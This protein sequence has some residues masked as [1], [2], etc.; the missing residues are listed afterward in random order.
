MNTQLSAICI[1]NTQIREINGLY[2][3]SDLHKASGGQSKHKPP[4][5]L[6]NQQTID[7]IEKLTELQICNLEQNQALSEAVKQV[8]LEDTASL[9][10][11][12]N[13]T[14]FNLKESGVHKMYTSHEIS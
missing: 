2:S 6:R 5:W 3:L 13:P 14:R 1:A 11:N 8:L 9:R 12:A 7:L 4:F 10:E